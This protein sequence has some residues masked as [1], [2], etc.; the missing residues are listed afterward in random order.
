MVPQANFNIHKTRC[1]DKA[2]RKK[3]YAE[4]KAKKRELKKEEIEKQRKS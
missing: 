3:K 1:A 4:K 2:Y